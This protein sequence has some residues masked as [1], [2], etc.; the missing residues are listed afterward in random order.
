MRATVSRNQKRWKGRPS[1]ITSSI[2]STAPHSNRQTIQK[3]K[4]NM[5]H[6]GALAFGQAYE[7]RLLQADP[8]LVLLGCHARRG[9]TSRVQQAEQVIGAVTQESASKEFSAE[10]M[11]G[12]A[13]QQ[14]RVKAYPAEHVVRSQNP[15]GRRHLRPSAFP[16]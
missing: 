4:K 10:G 1:K 13:S 8:L 6:C 7:D 14:E 11:N 12:I 2:Y 5:A 16:L 3:R 9:S 15:P